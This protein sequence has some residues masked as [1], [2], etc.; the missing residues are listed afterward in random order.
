[1]EVYNPETAVDQAIQLVEQVR[2]YY[3]KEA[4]EQTEGNGPF[5]GFVLLSEAAWD[6][7]KLA[8]DLRRDWQIEAA[9]LP[10]DS[11]EPL[12]FEVGRHDGG[13]QFD[14]GSDSRSGSRTQC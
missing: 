14:A 7:Q 10:K 4:E 12:V 8:A 6:P 13:D 9:D 11:S 2:A 5:A 1:M 3:M